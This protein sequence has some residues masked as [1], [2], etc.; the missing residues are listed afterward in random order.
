MKLSLVISGATEHTIDAIID[1]QFTISIDGF[2]REAYL[3]ENPRT[4]KFGLLTSFE[5]IISIERQ[6]P[7]HPKYEVNRTS[8]IAKDRHKCG[9]VDFMVLA[10]RYKSIFC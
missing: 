2:G 6:I 4:R 3:T 8:F 9:L 5:K 10:W 7:K 1:Q